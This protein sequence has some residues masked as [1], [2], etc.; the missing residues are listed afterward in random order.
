[1]STI[2]VFYGAQPGYWHQYEP[3]PKRQEEPRR[4]LYQKDTNFGHTKY[5][6]SHFLG[7][8]DVGITGPY[9]G[10]PKS[11]LRLPQNRLKWCRRKNRDDHVVRKLGVRKQDLNWRHFDFYIRKGIQ[12]VLR[13][14]R[15]HRRYDWVIFSNLLANDCILY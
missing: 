11:S 3:K 7:T 12:H 14:F 6:L 10:S 8:V 5:P 15:I 9:I 2:A 1:M 13:Q 4:P